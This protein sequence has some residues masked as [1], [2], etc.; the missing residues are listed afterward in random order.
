MHI[1]LFVQPSILKSS[2]GL[3]SERRLVYFLSGA[4]IPGRLGQ[5]SCKIAYMDQP[6]A[7]LLVG[8]AA[9]A[10]G[11]IGV[12]GNAAWTRRNTEK[13]W[14]SQQLVT[15]KIDLF[16]SM[17][18]AIDA[19]RRFWKITG[20]NARKLKREDLDIDAFKSGQ[21]ARN[22]DLK[23]VNEELSRA[24]ALAALISEGAATEFER[25][26]K[27]LPTEYEQFT[28]EFAARVDKRLGDGYEK[29]AFLGREALRGAGMRG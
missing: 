17:L 22:D 1:D 29:I 12:F 7:T 14:R 2:G 23:S 13:I 15:M 4:P 16:R 5:P 3:L 10:S 26:L 25:M 8:V 21:S 19:N 20:L 27:D 18:T 6:L 28:E 11:L 24:K 9:A